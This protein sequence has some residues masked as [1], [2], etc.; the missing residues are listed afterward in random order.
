MRKIIVHSFL[1]SDSE[2]PEIYAAD[3]ILAFNETEKGQ[4]L[5]EHSEIQMT[6]DILNDPM[7]MGYRVILHA[8]LSEQDL[9][10][11]NLKWS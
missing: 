1:L 3:P 7:V 10:Y 4:W 9:T 2:D 5:Y 11:Y 6:Y 8:W